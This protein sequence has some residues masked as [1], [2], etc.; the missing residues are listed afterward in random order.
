MKL[1]P[2]ARKLALGT[3]QFGLDYGVANQ[4]GQVEVDEIKQILKFAKESGLDTL[5]TAVGY[6]DSEQR[7]GQAGIDRWDVVTKLPALPESCEKVES[8]VKDTVAQSLNR[9]QIDRLKGLLLHRPGDLSTRR[10]E[11]LYRAMEQLKADG[12]VDKIGISIYAPEELDSL[13]SKYRLDIV[14]APFNILDR[15]MSK[16]GWLSRLSSQGTE[17]HTRSVFLQGLLL[18]SSTGRP[19]KFGRWKRIWDL[20]HSWLRQE[21]IS[22]L[23]ACLGFVLSE[24]AID[25]VVVGVDSLQQLRS[26]L[27]VETGSAESIPAQLSCDDIDLINPARWDSL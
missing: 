4:D 25:R 18:M 2:E 26:I 20:W 27:Q 17:I 12:L 3:V 21:D 19:G 1:S 11:K 5:D 14:Q 7:L 15:R 8:W 10:G 22:S 13:N 6:G 24:P 16:S 23:Q 9:L